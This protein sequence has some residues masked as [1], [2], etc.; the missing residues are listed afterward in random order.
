MY[1]SGRDLE[2]DYGFCLHL[3]YYCSCDGLL[4][5]IFAPTRGV[6]LSKWFNSTPHCGVILYGI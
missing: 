3:F 6:L 1:Q 4:V 5:E 2:F